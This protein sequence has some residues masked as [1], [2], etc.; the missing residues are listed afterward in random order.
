M[1]FFVQTL[2]PN[3]LIPSSA[4]DQAE[5]RA[6]QTM[7]ENLHGRLPGRMR[8]QRTEVRVV[9][10]PSLIT[11]ISEETIS[12]EYDL[13][14]LGAENRSMGERIYFGPFVEACLERIRCTVAVVVP[15]RGL[16]RR[17]R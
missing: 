5:M 3:P 8:R 11:S 16:G 6:H 10:G 7:L 2:D 15:S 17:N 1:V 14:V 4:T 13:V 12:G 9:E